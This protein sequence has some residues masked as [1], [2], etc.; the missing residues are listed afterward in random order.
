MAVEFTDLDGSR[1]LSSGGASHEGQADRQANGIE[2]YEVRINQAG[3]EAHRHDTYGIGITLSG[4]QTYNYRGVRWYSAPGECHFLHP[5]E[6]H[7]GT[8][9]TDDGLSYR[10]LYVAPA[11]VQAAVHGRAL[12]FVPEPVVRFPASI[13]AKLS[14]L[15]SVDAVLDDLGSVEMAVMAVEAIQT[16]C[17]TEPERRALPLERLDRVRH[18]IAS[19]PTGR[20]RLDELEILSGLDR[21]TL[22]RQFRAAFG[23]SP[24]RF[25]TLRQLDVV[26]R[27]IRQ[28]TSLALASAQAGFADQ[29]HMT[30]QFKGAYGLSPGRWAAAV[31]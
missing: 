23:T 28:G 15:W 25:R 11:M 16:A 30:R 20:C 24:T 3:F 27:E 13:V 17:G 10:I 2:R 4:G 6:R 18:L 29:S 21:W 14:M 22:A 19:N 12:P 5:D 9:V 8:S 7:D 31:R 1:A 26:R